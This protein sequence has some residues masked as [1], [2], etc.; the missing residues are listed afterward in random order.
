[1]EFIYWWGF[2]EDSLKEIE[3]EDMYN[4]ILCFYRS[5][6]R[7]ICEHL[8]ELEKALEN[9][10]TCLSACQGSYSISH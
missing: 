1:M 3:I 4:C 10:C 5:S 2:A 7:N 8:E 6:Y 9:T